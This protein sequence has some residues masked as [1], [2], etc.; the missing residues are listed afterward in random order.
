MVPMKIDSEM[1]VSVSA[2]SANAPM[3][4][5]APVGR[6]ATTVVLI[7]RIS[8]WLTARLTDSP[9]V[10]PETSPSS[11]VFSR[12]LSKTTV[13]SYSA[14]DRIVRNP[15]TAAGE[16]SKPKS[17]YTPIVITSTS[18][19]P[20]IAAADIFQVRKYS[21]RIRKVNARK[22]TR[23]HRDWRVTSAPQLG[24]MN[25]AVTSLDST[26]YASAR[27]TLTCRVSSA[28]IWS[29][30]TRIVSVPIVVTLVVASGTTV[31]TASVATA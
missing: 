18:T 24:P 11:L 21:P 13:V 22:I 8:V 29:V 5:I 1:S 26:L 14:Y 20:M 6:I 15:M 30:W 23:P 7:E 4:R 28:L 10:R 12:I 16:I 17:A 2:P 27:A 3:K 9:K 19:R 31:C 25:E